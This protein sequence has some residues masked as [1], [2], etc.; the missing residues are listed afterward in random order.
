MYLILWNISLWTNRA[1]KLGSWDIKLHGR[2]NGAKCDE[3]TPCFGS[4]CA[5]EWWPPLDKPRKAFLQYKVPPK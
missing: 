5:P 2:L 3:P 4:L 1:V